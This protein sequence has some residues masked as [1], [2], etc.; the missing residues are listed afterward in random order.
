MAR[1]LHKTADPVD[2][3]ISANTSDFPTVDWFINPDI[4]A[5]AGVPKK[6]WA[7]PLTDPVT[8]MSAGDKAVVDA[9]LD[10][11]RKDD[12]AD[13]F[14]AIDTVMRAFG[15]VVVDEFNTHAARINAILDAIDGAS[16][17][18]EVK[19]AIAAISD[20]NDRTLAQLKTAVRSK[21]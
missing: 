10:T 3:R 18:S 15:E 7:R 14:D 5:V 21:L 17:F 9:A 13:E 20:I 12:I 19:T 6:H 11:A 4:S 8:E 1:V 16:D 2:Y